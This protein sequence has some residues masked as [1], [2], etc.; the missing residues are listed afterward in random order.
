[1]RFILCKRCA[2]PGTLLENACTPRN[3]ALV[4]SA[5]CLLWVCDLD[6]K[7]WL[8]Q[9]R[10]CRYFGGKSDTAH[11][12]HDLP[13][14]TMDRLGVLRDVFSVEAKAAHVLLAEWS[15]IRV[16][17]ERT[18]DMHLDLGEVLDGRRP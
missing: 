10:I 9:G 2:L 13:R 12:R 6:Q 3:H 18:V 7:D 1:M 14:T 17:L 15:L 16:P 5:N 8:L 4:H 11:R